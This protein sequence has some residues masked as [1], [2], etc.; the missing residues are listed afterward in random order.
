VESDS[1]FKICLKKSDDHDDDGN[2]MVVVMMVISWRDGRYLF[3]DSLLFFQTRI[4]NLFM[5]LKF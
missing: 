2:V 3:P 5:S 1:E 4:S